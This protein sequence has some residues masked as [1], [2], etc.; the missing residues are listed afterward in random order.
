MHCLFLQPKD[1]DDR[2]YIE[3]PDQVKPEVC[4]VILPIV[5]QLSSSLIICNN[6]YVLLAP[7]I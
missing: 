5:G 6:L 4:F 2:E 1:W 7:G 3:D